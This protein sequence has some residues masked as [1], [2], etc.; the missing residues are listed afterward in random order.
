MKAWGRVARQ[1]GRQAA[2]VISLGLDPLSLN[3][4]GLLYC[5]GDIG[6]TVTASQLT[7]ADQIAA[8]PPLQATTATWAKGANYV[9]TTGALAK[10]QRLGDTSSPECGGG[11]APSFTMA[12]YY[13]PNAFPLTQHFQMG[14]STTAAANRLQASATY[15]GNL[16][17]KAIVNSPAFGDQYFSP[18]SGGGKRFFAIVCSGVGV[19]QAY[20][21]GAAVAWTGTHGTWP[22]AA[23]ISDA[24]SQFIQITEVTANLYACAAWLG[25]LTAA[26]VL[27]LYNAWVAKFGV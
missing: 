24:Y 14:F 25:Q 13:L 1:G 12:Y 11:A 21:Q 3:A 15:T 7:W 20:Y 16:E 5:T 26:N 22:P 9:T 23:G 6:A 10:A 27:A 19:F 18:M 17:G 4:N 8:N 2:R